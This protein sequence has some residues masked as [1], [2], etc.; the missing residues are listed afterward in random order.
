MIVWASRCEAIARH[1]TFPFVVFVEMR[2]EQT[3]PLKL[4]GIELSRL[5]TMRI[6]TSCV[7]ECSRYRRR[8]DIESHQRFL[9]GKPGPRLRRFAR[10]RTKSRIRRGEGEESV[11]CAMTRAFSLARV[12][13]RPTDRPG[14][15]LERSC[16]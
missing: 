4:R 6:E 2:M 10:L 11:T 9:A 8:I 15:I 13:C 14:L 5:P 7:P 12:G 3:Q 16:I 1:A